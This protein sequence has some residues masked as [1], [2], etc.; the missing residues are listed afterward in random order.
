MNGVCVVPR[1]LP[2]GSAGVKRAQR[3]PRAERESA[4]ARR[5]GRANVA[6]AGLRGGAVLPRGSRRARRISLR[7][8]VTAVSRAVL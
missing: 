8:R 3:D 6:G 5:G 4:S 1:D 7:I 2:S